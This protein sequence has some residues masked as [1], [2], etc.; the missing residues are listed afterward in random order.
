MI[1]VEIATD[2]LADA[3]GAVET[4]V[5][6]CKVQ[7]TEDGLSIRAVDPANVAM[8]DLTVDAAAFE[9]YD[10]TDHTVGL[11]LETLLDY[12]S[13]VDSE[14]VRVT[15]TDDRKL[16]IEGDHFSGSLAC[17][18]PDAIRQEPD[19]PDLDLDAT[20]T[21]RGDGLARGLTAADLVTDKVTF[22]ASS[23]A[24]AVVMSGE[25]DT[26]DVE[27]TFGDDSEALLDADVRGSPRSVFSL[28][29]WNDIAAPMPGDGAVSLQLGEEMPVK[30]RYSM[31]ENVV[32]ENMIA[33][34]VEA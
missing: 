18:D 17:I 26:D 21:L 13:A 8:V 20:V 6:E 5:A 29:Y 27:M 7:F 28:D 19:I 4:L 15:E 25:G 31:T 9:A 32:V 2:V 3:L 30:T 11:N 22:R 12:L 16:A 14:T 24:R 10:V 1:D 23:S 33:P 34:R